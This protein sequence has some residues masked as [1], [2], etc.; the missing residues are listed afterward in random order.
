MRGCNGKRQT[1]GTD[2]PAY[3]NSRVGGR[4]Y[5]P[6]ESCEDPEYIKKISENLKD[7]KHRKIVSESNKRRAK[8]PEFQK[9]ISKS[10]KKAFRTKRDPVTG[11]FIKHSVHTT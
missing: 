9:K 7:P 5:H 1:E 11:R 2:E 6:V 3:C 10:L 8:D 4:F